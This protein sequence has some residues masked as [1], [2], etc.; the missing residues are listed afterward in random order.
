[1]EESKLLRPLVLFLLVISILSKGF[2]AFT[3][4]NSYGSNV[5]EKNFAVTQG[6]DARNLVIEQ[7]KFEIKNFL[8]QNPE[9]FSDQMDLG[10][11]S[12][13]IKPQL[14]V[15]VS[16]SMSM[17]LLK[18]Y[19]KEV[20]LYGGTLVFKGLLND[21][22]KE[23]IRLV[24]DLQDQVTSHNTK[25]ENKSVAG[26]IIDDEAFSKY[27]VDV[28]PTIVLSKEEECLDEMTCKVT[29]DK[30]VGN[31]GIKGALEQFETSGDMKV[32]ANKMLAKIKSGW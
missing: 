5:E 24:T 29:Y 16:T 18:S 9:F 14:L 2:T 30:I 3:S 19:Y 17:Q 15:F 27:G 1:M 25:S 4:F 28:V 31:I 22:F 7:S 20:S 12:T 10:Q 21:S 6:I 26:V 8:Y 13:E 32:A 11:F 23:F